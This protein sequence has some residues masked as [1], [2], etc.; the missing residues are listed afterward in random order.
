LHPFISEANTQGERLVD[1]LDYYLKEDNEDLD[2][3]YEMFKKEGYEKI[4][5]SGMGSSYYAPMSVVSYLTSNSIPSI[6]INAYELANYQMNLLDQNTLLVLVSQSGESA[7]VIDVLN[8]AKNK[9]TILSVVNNTDSTLANESDFIL[10][11]HAGY[12]EFISSKSYL[13]TL[14]VL[15]L[16]AATLTNNLNNNYINELYKISNWVNE[17]LEETINDKEDMLSFVSD[18]NIFD[19]IGNGPSASNLYQSALI[20]REG[21]LYST[22]GTLCNEYSHGWNLYIQEGSTVVIFDPVHRINSIEHKML[23]HTLDNGGKVIL[24]TS[25]DGDDINENE[26]LTIRHPAVSEEL[27]TLLQII[28]CTMLMGW[29]LEEKNHDN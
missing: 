14:A 6:V 27:S 21:P 29:L 3:V 1:C 5:F 9:T 22:N 13:N 2:K 25:E 23:K 20:F 16:L 17:Y 11:M 26:T 10:N 12:E 4:V 19:F 8:K 28:P 24:I 18:T 15:Q 7:E